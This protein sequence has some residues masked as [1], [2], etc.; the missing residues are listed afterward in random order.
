MSDTFAEP[1]D[2]ADV[3]PRH[4]PGFRVAK[5]AFDVA[6]SLVLLIPTAVVALVLLAVNRRLNPGPLLFWQK[7]MGK[8][9]RAIRVVKFRSM[10]PV[11][12]ISRRADEPLETARITRLGQMLRRTRLD[13][14][15]QVLMVLRGD[16]SLIG[17]RPDYFAHALHYCAVI[18]GYRERHAVLP[19]ITGLAQ[20]DLGY[21]E[22]V[23]GTEAKVRADLRY[24][25]ERGWLLETRIVFDTVLTVLGA[26]GR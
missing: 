13:E 1:I 11:S 8:G 23:Q 4:V 18:P 17:P 2:V 3:T 7:R 12:R 14:L 25:R 19:G 21:A 24:I 6:V 5:R 9:G 22:G 20:I 16:M 26:R 15:P 10:I